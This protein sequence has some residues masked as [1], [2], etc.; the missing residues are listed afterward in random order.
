MS[1]FQSFLK[2]KPPKP[3]PVQVTPVPAHLPKITAPTAA[4]IAK[5]SQPSPAAQGILNANPKQTPPQYLGA[6]QEKQMGGDMVKTMAHGLPDREGVHWAA[7]SASKVSDKLP[8]SDVHAMQA[9]QTWA[10]NPTP[11]NKAAAAAAAAK[12]DYRGPGGL[13]AQ[14]AA[15]AQ[16]TTPAGSSAG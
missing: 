5:T 3:Q 11:E 8:P 7:Q 9:A 13:A 10:K 15:W 2:P 4:E 1:L 6:L 12:T 16:P 14:G